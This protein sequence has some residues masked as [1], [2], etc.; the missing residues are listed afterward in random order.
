[1][2][3]KTGI[4]F[5]IA[6]VAIIVFIVLIYN[7]ENSNCIAMTIYN[8][9]SGL[10]IDYKVSG[11][12]IIESLLLCNTIVYSEEKEIGTLYELY[13]PIIC[14]CNGFTAFCRI[15]IKKIVIMSVLMT[16]ILFSPIIIFFYNGAMNYC[17][18]IISYFVVLLSIIQ[19]GI[20]ITLLNCL[21]IKFNMNYIFVMLMM[22]VSPIINEKNYIP[23]GLLIL[24]PNSHMVSYGFI[25]YKL[26]FIVIIT[27]I[28]LFLQSKY[29]CISNE[30]TDAYE[31]RGK[32]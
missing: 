23:F 20:M 10:T 2:K 29:E 26:L 15:C 5:M 4:M 17:E 8:C 11:F 30:F 7:T 19:Y 24:F 16:S 9:Y 1:M 25:V 6:V 3:N 31:K 27:C 14:R 12:T 28:W 32:I 21:H 18:L 13:I 22:I